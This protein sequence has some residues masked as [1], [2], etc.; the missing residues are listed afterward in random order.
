MI[1]IT[2]NPQ[3]TCLALL[4]VACCCLPMLMAGQ[5]KQA[6]GRRRGL[7]NEYPAAQVER[8]RV[9]FQK[10]CGFCHGPDANGGSTG[11]N[12][13]R[14]SVVRHDEKGDQIGPVVRNGFPGK[15][16]PAFQLS[17]D[18]VMDIV[19][20]LRFRLDESDRRSAAQAGA[21]Y[22]LA[23]LLVG[24][25]EA[26]KKFFDGAGKCSSCHSPAGD[27]KGIAG[28]YPP[29]DL[30][31]RM[32]YPGDTQAPTATVTDASGKEYTGAVRL[33]SHYD[34]AIVDGSG[35]YRSWPLNSV[36]VKLDDRLAAHRQLLSVMTD[37]DMH[38]LFAYLET[39]K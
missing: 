23:K 17:S 37:A 33:L 29:A 30:Q 31:A 2:R 18:Q 32:L 4:V 8:G 12:L 15:G 3:Q 26:G 19:A 16:M 6:S 22:S 36:K 25:A 21:G 27:L 28:K 7:W 34:V 20:F 9:Q 35:W 1:K 13:M 24:N 11:P 38:N 10:T 14:S 39:L 5:E